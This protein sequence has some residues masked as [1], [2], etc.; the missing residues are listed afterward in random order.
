M[1]ILGFVFFS[2]FLVTNFAFA[3]VFS[4]EE[5]NTI[6]FNELNNQS[7]TQKSNTEVYNLTVGDSLVGFEDNYW[8]DDEKG[9]HYFYESNV[10]KYDYY[11]IEKRLDIY[12]GL[13]DKYYNY[14]TTHEGESLIQDLRGVISLNS[15][16][17]TFTKDEDDVTVQ[18]ISG[19]TLNLCG[20]INIS[21]PNHKYSVEGTSPFYV[22]CGIYLEL[23]EQVEYK[24]FNIIGNSLNITSKEDLSSFLVSGI[25][26]GNNLVLGDSKSVTNIYRWYK[27]NKYFRK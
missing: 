6:S 13:Y 15:L 3:K 5:N 18:Y 12:P 25:S 2:S 4:T 26:L 19:L 1:L 20:D 11:P 23:N 17:S 7:D 14:T 27:D 8:I 24:D 22:N 21:I 9:H 10:M 16:P